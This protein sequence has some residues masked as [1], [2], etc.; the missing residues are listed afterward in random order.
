MMLWNIALILFVL[1]LLA[2][3]GFHLLGAAVHILLILAIITA[4]V[5]LVKR[6]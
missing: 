3:L 6:A 5:A 1:W 4:V 2:W